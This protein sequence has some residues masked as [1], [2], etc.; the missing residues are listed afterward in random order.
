VLNVGGCCRLSG[1]GSPLD[2]TEETGGEPEPEPLT[3]EEVA[4]QNERIDKEARRSRP[5]PASFKSLFGQSQGAGGSLKGLVTGLTNRGVGGA[6][7][8]EVEALVQAANR[9]GTE[10][11]KRSDKMM[12]VILAPKLRYR[13]SACSRPQVL[14]V[15]CVAT[16]GDPQ[17]DGSA[18]R[19]ALL[20]G[21]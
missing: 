17:R 7:E 18:Q 14:T 19:H 8:E 16:A 15:V 4:V 3:K 21:A 11:D 1:G 12:Q 2:D 10:A 5:I 20:G 6:E 13:L 9:D